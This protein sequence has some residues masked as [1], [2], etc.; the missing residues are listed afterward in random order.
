MTEPSV[1]QRLLIV[2]D[3]PNVV[4]GLQALLADE[5][6]VKTAMTAREARSVFADFS[7]DVV[8]LDMNLPDGN[9]VDVL[10]DLKMYSEAVSVIMMSGVGTVDSVVESMKLGAETFLQKPFDY[11]LLSLTL[12]QVARM[13]ATRRELIALRRGDANEQ[14]RLPGLSPA[15][16]NLNQLLGQIARAP[17]PV[18]I[19]GDSGTGKGV[20]ARLIHNRS[21]RARA[22]F[23][24]LNCA[25]L[26]KELLESE[27]FGHERGA[28]TNA[29]NTKQGL[30][31]IAADGTLFLDEIGEM[32]VT[33]QARLLKAIEDKRFR[34]VGGIRDLTANFR[35]VAA[36]NRDLAAEVAANRFRAD[37]Y[38]R[39]NVVRVRMPPLRERIED[40]PLL[41]DVILRP[42][43]KEL[44]RPAPTVSPRAL[45]KL[46][47][48]AWPGNV[49]EL[50]NVLERAM[51]T[52]TGKEIMN[53]DLL[54]ESETKSLAK[55]SSGM[56]TADWEIRALDDVVADY[57]TASVT[58][59][60]GN[61]RKAARQLQI[62]P[63]TLYARM[64]K[65]A[66]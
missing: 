9:G 5:W 30:F 59:A 6:D 2:D 44:G 43:S 38:Y 14:E 56:P 63:S 17:S 45:K 46:Q 64:N 61:V 65:P 35:L 29:M 49:R 3:E 66:T 37:L 12:E 18:L 11:S 41:V 40:I 22:P 24:D 15:V 53:D 58:A 10:H 57:V 34:R 4:A 33:V 27:L 62:S 16:Q 39:L 60:G 1:K 36:T 48:Y 13:V 47:S 52:M 31:E 19:E 51:L 42:L 55:T 23:V 32:D 26:S 7:P 50:R 21:P 8:L 25:G 20:F 54:L 28:F